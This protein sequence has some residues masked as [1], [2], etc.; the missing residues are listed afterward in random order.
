[1]TWDSIAATAA[2]C[3]ASSGLY[4]MPCASG[5]AFKM[6]VSCMVARWSRRGAT[7]CTPVA[8]FFGSFFARRMRSFSSASDRR[9]YTGSRK[10]GLWRAASKG[11]ASPARHAACSA[12]SKPDPVGAHN[13]SGSSVPAGENRLAYLLR[14]SPASCRGASAGWAP[15]ALS[16][17]VASALP[18]SL[19]APVPLAGPAARATNSS[20]A[21]CAFT[22]RSA[23][24][25]TAPVSSSAKSTG[26]TSRRMASATTA[27][28]PRTPPAHACHATASSDETPTS[29]TPKAEATPFAVAMAMRTP[30]NDPGPRPTHTHASWLRST[31]ACASS[32]SMRGSS[33]VFDARL[34]ATST[35]STRSTDRV[36]RSRRPTPMAITSFAVSNASTYAASGMVIPSIFSSVGLWF[37]PGASRTATPRRRA[38]A[39]RRWRNRA[40]AARSWKGGP[41]RRSPTR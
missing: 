31:P 4:V 26:Y 21:S 30:V 11:S 16:L 38:L 17:S 9:V 20:A 37:A 39:V 19:V 13:S 36:S 15:V 27:S 24:C 1:M 2:A 10:P 33:C 3:A 34:A 18:V 23:L 12:S 29:A 28:C 40:E 6:A 8:R 7:S 35:D 22:T 14:P 41:Q 5:R 25:R 32:A